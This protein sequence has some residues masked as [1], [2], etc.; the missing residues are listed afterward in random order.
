MKTKHPA[1]G[2][3]L[4][5]VW[6]IGQVAI[7]AAMANPGSLPSPPITSPD[8]RPVGKGALTEGVQTLFFVASWNVLPGSSVAEQV[9]VNHL[10]AGSIPARAAIR[11][12][13][14]VRFRQLASF[15]SCCGL[16]NFQ[17]V[18]AKTMCKIDSLFGLALATRH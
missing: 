3:D 18:T 17:G 13:R 2:K 14:V 11:E 15:L 8:C 6:F 12:E 4:P 9:T 5:V 1:A 10:V 16:D 7:P